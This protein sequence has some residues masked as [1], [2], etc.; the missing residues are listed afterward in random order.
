M[1]PALTQDVSPARRLLT[2]RAVRER[3][4]LLLERGLA[5]DLA[6]FRVDLDRLGRAA[7]EVLATMRSGYPTLDIPF[8]ARWRHFVAGGLDRWEAL[9]Q[10][11][12]WADG[13]DRA[14]ASFDLAI[15]SVLLDAGA[16]PDW[17]YEEGRTG[18]TFSRSEGLAVASFDMFVSGAF[19]GRPSEPFRADAG[20]L[21]VMDACELAR[22]FQV[23]VDNPLVGLA[24]RADIL[25]RLGRTVAMAPD[26]FATRDDPRPGG[27]FDHLAS[28]AVKETLP[29]T[30]ILEALLVHLG[31][32]WP[33]RLTLGGLDLGDTWHHPAIVTGDDTD[34]L[35][36]FHKLSQWLAYSLIEPLEAAGITVTDLD[37]LTGL[38]EYRNGGLFLDTGVLQLRDPGAA[39]RPQEVSSTLVV[40]WRAL[41]VALLDLV[42]ARIRSKL[43]RSAADFPLAKVL[44]GGTWATGRRL[45]HAR[46][47][48]G[49]PPLTVISDG[50]VF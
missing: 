29:A 6:H 21:T 8:H 35:I 15:V 26:I 3:A 23:R 22:G 43:G 9:N 19:S 16:G 49:A 31:P 46:R 41:T 17:R 14:R 28:L 12:R 24:G 34:G 7:D 36:P 45:A 50:T 18:E 32:V 48:R 10:T 40:E 5:D 20:I 25:N 33:G 11:V 27:L 39:T 1:E 47:R 44:E 38:P 13:R 37:G 4:H 30:A 2:A 42:A